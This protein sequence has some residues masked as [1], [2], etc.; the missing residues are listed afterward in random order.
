[1]LL[2]SASNSASRAAARAG[3][4]AVALLD[5][6]LDDDVTFR[7][8]AV[9]TPQEGRAKARMYL[10]AAEKMFADSG[11]HYVEQWYNERSAILQFRA[12]LD[13]VLVEGIDMIH[14][15]DAGRIVS[16]TVMIRPLKALQSVIPRMGELLAP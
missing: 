16:F 11:F 3:D 14:W 9:F 12:D 10:L 8:P 7:S 2:A 5:D 4:E 13:G 15:S 6:L 1:M